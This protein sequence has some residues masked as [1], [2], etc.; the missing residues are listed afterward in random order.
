MGSEK[1]KPVAT[2]EKL[3]ELNLDFS[4]ERALKSV[5]LKYQAY[6]QLSLEATNK[7]GLK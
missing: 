5:G 1:R 4:V 3:L 6:F 7:A 2:G